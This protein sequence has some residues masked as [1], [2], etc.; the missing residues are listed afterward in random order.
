MITIQGTN[1]GVTITS[2]AQAGTVTEDAADTTSTT[3]SLSA[4]GTVA[5]NDIDLTDTHTA[6]FVQSAGA[7][8]LGV[9]AL[10]SVSEL[11]TT[12][13]GSVGWSY[14][15]TNSAAQYLGADESVSETYTVTV[16]DEAGA[17]NT[18]A[19]VITIQGTNDRPLITAGVVSGTVTEDGASDGI[20]ATVE[21]VNG[22]FSVAD[23]DASDDLSV[24]GFALQGSS[25]SG[26]AT[27][28]VAQINALATG[29]S[30]AGL[31]G[32]SN[33]GTVSWTYTLPNADA[34]ILNSGQRVTLT[35]RVTVTDD[36]VTGNATAFQD[37]T[38][39][40]N[41]TNDIVNVAPDARNDVWV[42]SDS[43]PIA[44]GIITAAWFTNNDTDPDGNPIFVT[45]VSGLPTGLVANYDGSGH[46]V[47]ITG[48][49]PA[50]GS[51]TLTYTLSDGS[52][53]DSASVT[54]TVIDTTPNANSFILDGNDFSYIDALSGVDT[55]TGDTTLTGN[56]GIDHFIGGPGNDILNG[57]DGNDKLFGVAGDD[58]LN[59][60]AGNDYLDGGG[61][62]DTLNGGL[63]ND[64]LVWDSADI[65]VD[66]GG[67]TDTLFTASSIDLTTV[68]DA[69]IENIDIID[70]TG[71]GNQMI[72][73]NRADV[74]T[75]LESDSGILRILGNTGDTVDFSEVIGS[76]SGQWTSAGT[77]TEGSQV[78]NV[79]TNTVSAV[80]V[81][82][83]ID[84]DITN[85]I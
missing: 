39:T 25:Q 55:L 40:I 65:L 54:V 30:A 81:M 17:F 18:Q 51:Y 83:Y 22:S 8:P 19:V 47:S 35:F 36:S 12:E 69:K 82:A 20:P 72:T 21:V 70:M 60:G 41:G 56:A 75:D 5:F 32:V 53:T 34:Q 3:D 58:T 26:G 37:V 16:T 23:V 49:S 80:T 4:A 76:S 10:G 1:D 33:S 6:G 79:Y 64:I 9:F 52:L 43:T 13:P 11:A 84:N 29:F 59:G 73:L 62:N 77:V 2:A 57:G 71:N 85:V 45:A 24:V 15:L 61:N 27:L 7:T 63:G 66:G 50:A 28:T 67:G 74:L 46:L 48:T 44:A 38:I 78:Y 68:A 14:N 42:L 31:G